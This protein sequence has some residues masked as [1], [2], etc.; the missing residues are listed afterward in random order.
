VSNISRLCHLLL[1]GLSHTPFA[2]NIA[3]KPVTLPLK[4]AKR[5]G[6]R[7]MD[8]KQRNEM[9]LFRFSLIAPLIN[10]T[11]TGSVKDYLERVCAKAHQVPYQGLKEFSP[12][13]VRKWLLDY[14][15]FGLEG[16][17]RKPRND[18]GLTRTLNSKMAYAIKEIKELHP[19]RTA[20]SIYFTLLSNGMLGNPPVSL[21][22]V[23][24]YIRKL[25][26]PK[27]SA[28]ERKRF[29]FEFAGDCWQTDTLHGPYLLINGRKKRTYLMLIL[30]DASRLIVHGEFFFEENTQNLQVV[31]KKAILKR[32]I[33]KRLFGDQGKVYVSLHLRMICA[34]LGIILIHA[35]PYSPSS[36][37]KIERLFLTVRMQFLATL[38]L[39]EVHSLEELNAKFLTYAESVYNQKPHS[40]L[41]GLSPMERYLK[42][43]GRLKFVESQELLERV[44]LHEVNRKVKKDATISILNR[45]F[46]V[47]QPFIGQSIKVRFDP[48]DL[49]KV[50]VQTGEPP[51]LTPVYP[52]RPVDNSKVI[53]KQNVRREIDFA[54]LYGGEKDDV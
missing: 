38:D 47:P 48:E 21:S 19:H 11:E 16:L 53:R 13:T 43:Q 3:S 33:P 35:R 14:R 2:V 49:S 44:F 18:K 10:G 4:I 6:R 15:R 30:D 12:S 23:N 40:S 42:D 45:V 36:K 41:D 5:S 50:F 46:E 20:T 17:K 37:G 25:E 39:S 34:A 28:V 27:D 31:L 22:T 32:G 52:V 9:A 1:L 8:E 26:V 54:T 7:P 51:V 29:C 24:R